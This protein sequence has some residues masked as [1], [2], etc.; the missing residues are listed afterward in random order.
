MVG[1]A[2]H[3]HLESGAGASILIAGSSNFDNNV[4]T[5]LDLL[6]EWGRTDESY[7]Q[8]VANLSGSTVNGVAPNG[9]GMNGSDFLNATTVQD[10]G[11]GDLL[12]G[13]P[14]LDW[15]LANLDGSGNSG[16]KDRVKDRQPGEI[17]T[18]IT[19]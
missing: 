11:T 14:G 10:D 17:V 5:L 16:V 12:E 13:G 4:S 3:D 7:L 6:S 2:G 18:S 19:L 15:F 8:R 9:Q 1:G